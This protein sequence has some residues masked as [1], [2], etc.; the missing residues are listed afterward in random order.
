MESVPDPVFETHLRV[1]GTQPN[2][3][4]C[5]AGEVCA[6]IP[7]VP[8]PNTLCI[9]REG[10][11]AC[12]DGP[13]SERIL[14]YRD[15]E[16]DRACGPEC[17]CGEPDGECSGAGLN[18]YSTDTCVLET[19]P[20][21][22]SL[23]DEGCEDAALSSTIRGIRRVGTATFSGSCSASGFAALGELTPVDPVTA[24]CTS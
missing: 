7:S 17:T 21:S 12:P 19:A 8:F 2:E 9:Y 3:G 11:H 5:D 16:D 4:G 22:G 13:F 15:F 14:H 20:G 10:E 23:S 6:P 1:C 18:L 24:C